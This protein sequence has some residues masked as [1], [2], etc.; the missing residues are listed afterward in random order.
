MKKAACSFITLIAV[1]LLLT[2]CQQNQNNAVIATADGAK[3]FDRYCVKC[4][5]S[6]GTGGISAETGGLNSA[7]IRQFKKTPAELEAIIT[8]GFGKMPAFGDSTSK[9]N[10]SMI[11][12]YVATQIEGKN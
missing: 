4:H 12:A 10:I 7:D 9:E 6:N 8:N 3:L 5:L 1:L 11:A 2:R